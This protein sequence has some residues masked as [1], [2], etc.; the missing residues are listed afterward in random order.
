M[1]LYVIFFSI[2]WNDAATMSTFTIMCHFCLRGRRQVQIFGFTSLIDK[3]ESNINMKPKAWLHQENPS[4]NCINAK[5]TW[6][7][8]RA[9]SNL[10]STKTCWFHYI[11]QDKP[12]NKNT[13][14]LSLLLNFSLSIYC[15]SAL[16]DGNKYWL[17]TCIMEQLLWHQKQA[18]KLWK[19]KDILCQKSDSQQFF[20]WKMLM[21]GAKNKSKW[22]RRRVGE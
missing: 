12:H 1:I 6:G 14:A 13:L 17:T 22:Q 20:L 19:R 9:Y 18:R 8:N 3:F 15:V 2:L 4:C 10:Y 5:M 21:C 11:F 7:T 16:L